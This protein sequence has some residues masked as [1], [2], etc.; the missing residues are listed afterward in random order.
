MT[1]ARERGR[2]EGRK[3]KVMK[4]RTAAWM[5]AAALMAWAAQ[6][7]V[8]A[9][10]Q[11]SPIP[12]GIVATQENPQI[13]GH[14]LFTGQ[15]TGAFGRQGCHTC[16]GRDG[17]G[18]AEGT[19]PDLIAALPQY[20][21]ATLHR[22]LVSGLAA[23]GRTLTRLMPRVAVSVAEAG[24]LV[25]YLATLPRRERQGVTP[26]TVT[27]CLW[28][29]PKAAARYGQSL[30]NAVGRKLAGGRLH[31]RT[32][33]FLPAGKQTAAACLAIMGLPPDRRAIPDAMRIGLPVLYPP[34][35][36][37]GGE[38]ATVLRVFGG[39]TRTLAA[40]LG[41]DLRQRAVT[42]IEVLGAAPEGLIEALNYEIPGLQVTPTGSSAVLAFAPP[43]DA[44]GLDDGLIYLF[45]TA[46]LRNTPP[47][48]GAILVIDRPALLA[49][50]N[51]LDLPPSEA[52]AD[53]AAT[54][55]LAGIVSAG[56]DLTRSGMMR[57]LRDIPLPDHDFTRHPLT[58]T[59]AVAILPLAGAADRLK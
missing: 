44:Q 35:P 8:G 14:D 2:D 3:R 20:D 9:P 38:D 29:A 37:E 46:L 11:A 26:G 17:R 50:A 24:L 56:R 41:Q 32:I 33:A 21:A 36:V 10:Q 6:T 55:L 22:A 34:V 23:D 7:G 25:T 57:A 43:S 39:A 51:R 31:G 52:H 47:P 45:P 1:S 19:T 40:A 42:R 15:G 18:G 4:P 27:I 58:G 48:K 54:A 49:H 13:E 5:M 12:G 53:L 30:R 59:E 28:D 16:H